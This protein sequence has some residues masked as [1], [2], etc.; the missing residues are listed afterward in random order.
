MKPTTL[1]L[2]ICSLSCTSLHAAD[3]K[4]KPEGGVSPAQRTEAIFKH[5]DSDKNGKINLPEFANC[6]L[7]KTIKE[8]KGDKAVGEIFARADKNKDGELSRG[9]LT[10]LNNHKG[11]GNDLTPK[12]KKVKSKGKSKAKSKGK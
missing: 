5:S 4:G 10:H 7:G 1:F 9:E 6:K 2:L 11:K 8:E 3:N 12:A